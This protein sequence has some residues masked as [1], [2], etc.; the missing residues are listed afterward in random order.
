MAFKEAVM[1]EA[2]WFKKHVD[3]CDKLL[4]L[5]NGKRIIDLE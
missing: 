4:S 1:T 5:M 2:A 3:R